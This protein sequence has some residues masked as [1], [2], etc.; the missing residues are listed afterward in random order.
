M[1]VFELRASDEYGAAIDA[2]PEH[3]KST[4]R[5]GYICDLCEHFYVAKVEG[6]KH[7][8]RVYLNRLGVPQMCASRENMMEGVLCDY[9]QEQLDVKPARSAMK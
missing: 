1:K 4:L 7:K 2:L 8:V 9:C 5:R 6:N 3:L